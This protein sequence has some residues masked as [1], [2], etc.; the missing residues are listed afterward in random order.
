MTYIYRIDP[1]SDLISPEFF[2]QRILNKGTSNKRILKKAGDL[3]DRLHVNMYEE[4][5]LYYLLEN[6]ANFDVWKKAYRLMRRKTP[7]PFF[8]Q[9]LQQKDLFDQYRWEKSIAA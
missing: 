6:G 1:T 7:Y 4:S 8:R 3:I 5:T 9:R 2:Y